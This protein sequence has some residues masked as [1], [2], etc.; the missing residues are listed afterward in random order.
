MSPIVFVVPRSLSRNSLNWILISCNY[1]SVI[2]TTP[3]ILLA[4]FRRLLQPPALH[5]SASVCQMLEQGQIFDVEMC[6]GS[7]YRTRS[8]IRRTTQLSLKCSQFPE[9]HC[10]I[11]WFPGVASLSFCWEHRGDYLDKWRINFFHI[12]QKTLRLLER[13]AVLRADT[14]DVCGTPLKAKAEGACS[15]HCI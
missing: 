14:V 2:L 4:S 13:L 3:G 9:E 8:H 7:W 11:R 12:S 6:S 1:S 5:I 15:F 10:F